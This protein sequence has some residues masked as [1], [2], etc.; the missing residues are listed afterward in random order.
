MVFDLVR[1]R[2]SHTQGTYP[3][4]QLWAGDVAATGR[5]T[6]F[7]ASRGPAILVSENT[8]VC[9]LIRWAGA[10]QWYLGQCR[11]FCVPHEVACPNLKGIVLFLTW[12]VYR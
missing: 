6:H 7:G 9:T 10:L 2:V 3:W 5:D 11:Q 12:R 4:S 8:F 1:A